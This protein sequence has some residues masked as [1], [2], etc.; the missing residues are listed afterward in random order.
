MRN[1]IFFVLFFITAAVSAQN[2]TTLLL[3]NFGAKADGKILPDGIIEFGSAK[4]TSPSAIFL[5]GD[6]G[7]TIY[8]AGAAVNGNTLIASIVS[9]SSNTTVT[10][11][12]KASAAVNHAG[13]TYGTDCTNAFIQFNKVARQKEHVVLNLKPGTYLTKFNNYLA[14]IKSVVLN[15]NGCNLICTHGAYEPLGSARANVGLFMPSCFDNVDNNYYENNQLGNINVGYKIQSSNERSNFVQTINATDAANFKIGD[16]VLV[17]GLHHEDFGGWPPDPRFFEYAKIKKLAISEGLIYLDRP[18]NNLYDAEWPDGKQRNG[19]GAARIINLDRDNFT[20][21]ENLN[22]NNVHFP[23]FNGW[24]GK[25]STDQR[26]SRFELYGYINGKITNV[27]ASAAYLGQGKNLMLDNVTIT[28]G[29]E[30][31]KVL[32]SCIIKN[33]TLTNFINAGGLNY[34]YLYNNTFLGG[35]N[36]S[37]HNLFVE[38]N[39]FKTRGTTSQSLAA[40]GFN[41][42]TDY[43]KIGKNTWDCSDGSKNAL[44]SPPS[45]VVMT[46]NTVINNN[47]IGVLYESFVKAHNSRR[48]V[49]GSTGYTASGK[50]FTVTRVYQYDK[51]YIAVSGKFNNGTPEADDAYSFSMAPRIDITGKQI[52]I[53]SNAGNYSLFQSIPTVVKLNYEKEDFKN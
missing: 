38:N 20:V 9:I 43:I 40:F 3:E 26:N 18:L 13:I 51:D 31:D 12:I 5:P 34:L 45:S 30:P 23:P 52:K 39:T 8:I 33:C 10:L 48:I 19:V 22:I 24:N 7:K 17:Y 53:G 11:S 15:G 2:T 1:S 29:C 6:V 37:P 41:K 4:L 35:F 14:G 36:A 44:I 47:T 27:N 21:V 16:W 25:L 32:D 28:R 49:P 46:V 42:G 50:E